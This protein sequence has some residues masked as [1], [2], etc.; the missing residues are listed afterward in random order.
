M[1]W[2]TEEKRLASGRW[3]NERPVRGELIVPANAKL[4]WLNLRTKR[5]LK[6]TADQVTRT[7]V[8]RADINRY[9]RLGAQ[10]LQAEDSA[11]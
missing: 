5:P 6:N 4:L 1:K 7:S 8:S 9:D 11:Q 2:A 10:R 3:R